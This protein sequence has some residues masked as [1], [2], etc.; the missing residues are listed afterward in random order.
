VIR[1]IDLRGGRADPAIVVPRADVAAHDVMAQVE[2]IIRDVAERG[3]TAVAEWT[4]RLDGVA[5][6]QLRVPREMLAD[7]WRRLAPDVREALQIA[8]DRVRRVHREQSPRE[9]TTEVV[10]GGTVSQ[11]WIPVRRVGLYVPGGRAVYPSSVIMNVVPAQVAGVPSLAVVSP[12]QRDH[13]GW[14]HP[15]V[16]A[17]CHMLGVDELYAVGGAQ[18][19]ALLAYG[20]ELQPDRCAPVDLV[21][22]P[23]NVWVT[24]AKRAVMGRV[25]IDSEAGPTEVMVIADDTADPALVAAD[26]VSQAEHDPLAAAVLVTDSAALAHEVGEQLHGQV[27]A[28]KHS[29]RIAEALSGPQS[30]VLLVTGIDAAVD[31]A[32]A[33][34]AE[35][36]EIHTAD[37]DA[38]AA[39]ITNAGAVFIGSYTPVSLGDYAAGSNHVLPTSGMSA[40]S[41]GLGVHTFL[42][43]VQTIRYDRDALAGIADAVQVLAAEED[44]PA[45][46]AA[47]AVRFRDGGGTAT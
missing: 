5:P 45:H 15:T 16:L 23:G 31:V 44:L 34:G 35:H 39:R 13:G 4:L 26:L 33:Y 36:L 29:Q 37:P 17:T 40:H 14:P 9:S 42:R 11:R 3:A 41:S 32:N 18:A 28:T 12:P 30:A 20:A 1:V 24:A 22:G 46:G 6:P 27:M 19:V 47:I 25:G 21:T 8:A 43:S 38:V 7:S 2:P 10:V